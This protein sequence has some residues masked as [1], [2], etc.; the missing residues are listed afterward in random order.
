M[1]ICNRSFGV[2]GLTVS[3]IGFGAF[4]VGRNQKTKYPSAYDLPGA[5]ASGRL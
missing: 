1:A 2:S 4:K 5:D 3:P